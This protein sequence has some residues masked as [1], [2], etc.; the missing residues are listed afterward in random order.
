ME[1]AWSMRRNTARSNSLTGKL[2]ALQTDET[3]IAA[4]AACASARA[5]HTQREKTGVFEVNC[6]QGE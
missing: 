5:E 2:Y 1:L 6:L 3:Q 4:A